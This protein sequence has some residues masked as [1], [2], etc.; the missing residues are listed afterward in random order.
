VDGIGVGLGEASAVDD[1]DQKFEVLRALTDH[2]IRG[3]WEEIRH[4]S[5]EELRRTL[6]LAIPI[7]EASAKI[8]GG[9]PLDDEEDYALPVWAGVVPLNF[10]ASEPIADPRLSA[11][12]PVPSYAA[13]YDGPRRV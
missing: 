13:R 5:P 10:S 11:D 8:R 12:V 2:L 3:R 9:P 4:P 6:V 7:E 1:P